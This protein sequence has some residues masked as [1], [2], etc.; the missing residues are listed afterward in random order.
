MTDITSIEN[1]ARAAVD[2]VRLTVVVTTYERPDYLRQ[3]LATI[4]AQSAKDSFKV[5]VQDNASTADNSVVIAEYVDKMN[6]EYV[7]NETNLGA[8]GNIGL[9]LARYRDTEY[10][11]VFHDDDLMHPRMLE[12]QLRQ[13]DADAEILFIAT[14]CAIFKDGTPPPFDLWE[15]PVEP[16]YDVYSDA[17]GFVRG[18]L[19][20]SE[21][22]L[23][24]VM[25]RTR[26]LDCVQVD[27]ER[28]N[29]YGDRPYLLS[30]AR[31]G[32][33]ALAK[34]PLV[35]YR[36][37]GAQD[38]DSGALTFSILIELMKEYRD[39]LDVSVNVEDRELFMKH[40]A[41]F[42]PHAYTRLQP[43][44]R[45]T[46]LEFLGRARAEG[47]LRLKDIS[48]GSWVR[49]LWPSGYSSLLDGVARMKRIVGRI[50]GK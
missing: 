42:L 15:C 33:S 47:V 40:S 3:S 24:S 10:L 23:S 11:T 45:P 2:E 20:G 44:K 46:R 38:S 26:V 17:A 37:H 7:R 6:L 16:A 41:A 19:S 8:E 18:I 27:F 35:L 43:A 32:K 48:K 22:A 49:L 1:G 9:A 34:S 4:A 14:Q 31:L 50:L 13:M 12:W 28:F 25:Y 30:I 5:I 21:P 39:T 29:L 36:I